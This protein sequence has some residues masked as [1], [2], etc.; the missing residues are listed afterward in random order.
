M[1]KTKFTGFAL[2]LSLL[3]SGVFFP[4]NGAQAAEEIPAPEHAKR[5]ADFIAKH[6]GEQKDGALAD[7]IIALAAA[8]EHKDKIKEAIEVLKENK[9]Y[10]NKNAC[11]AAKVA[12][13]VEAVGQDPEKIGGINLIKKASVNEDQGNF[14]RGM[15]ALAILRAG[16]ELPEEQKKS[17]LNSADNA[18]KE[19][20]FVDGAGMAAEAL[21]LLGEK[22]SAEKIAKLLISKQ[23][24]NGSWNDNT[25]STGMV[26][27]AL[28]KL[29][30][31]KEANKATEW[32]KTKQ[33][34]KEGYLEPSFD[35]EGLPSQILATTQGIFSLTNRDYSNALID[36]NSNSGNTDH[37][38]SETPKPP[39]NSSEEAVLVR[40]SYKTCKTEGVW[41]I[42]QHESKI[43]RQGC[44]KNAKNALAAV[45]ATGAKVSGKE[46]AGLGLFVTEIDGKGKT[47]DQDHRYWNFD[48]GKY[49]KD[50]KAVF[51][52]AQVGVSS[53]EP[54]VGEILGL[55]WRE[56]Q[57]KDTF[58]FPPVLVDFFQNETHISK[59]KSDSNLKIVISNLEAKQK[60]KITL[61]NKEIIDEL[62]ADNNGNIE[63]TFKLPKL[64]DKQWLRILDA[65]TNQILAEIEVS[66]E[67]D[68][69]PD[70]AQISVPD[71]GI[72]INLPL[73]GLIF[74][75]IISG[76]VLSR[77]S[78]K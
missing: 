30:H 22:D 28:F 74:S 21:M 50:G 44:V 64:N 6:I 73:L 53:Y 59:A 39:K 31:K 40:A 1:S 3:L 75:A 14:C 45:K 2:G 9:E 16:K 56:Y 19:Y 24:S 46:Y 54:K 37:D 48:I 12:L 13:A 17:L 26:S 60:I 23:N 55:I 42:V 70:K 38:D 77:S 62:F 63:K 76:M 68:N 66:G 32:M 78:K 15:V 29:G 57:G 67:V 5:A 72:D 43:L 35:P 65:S 49:D 58:K 33:N 4:L 8:G 7:S 25:N 27:A 11:S 52:S 71:T 10:Q 41:V 69:N 20:K 51:T 36:L 18:S 47:N 61:G 34:Q